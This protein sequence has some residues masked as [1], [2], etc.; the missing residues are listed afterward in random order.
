MKKV[1][2]DDL[3]QLDDCD[4]NIFV[5]LL[6]NEI[7]RVKDAESEEDKT[8]LRRLCINLTQLTGRKYSLEGIVEWVEEKLNK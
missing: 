6:M 4:L 5:R 8:Y 1:S 7:M 3:Y 2:K